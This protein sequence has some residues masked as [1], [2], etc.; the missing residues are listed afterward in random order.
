VSTDM[1]KVLTF[2]VGLGIVA[3]GGVSYLLSRRH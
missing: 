2:L 3:V 1:L